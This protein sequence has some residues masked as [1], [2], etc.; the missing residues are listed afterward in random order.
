MQT[1]SILFKLYTDFLIQGTFIN[2]H[3]AKLFPQ[4]TSSYA[5]ALPKKLARNSATATDGRRIFK[6]HPKHEQ[7]P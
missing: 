7:T 1:V 4:K 2:I 5:T 6:G 3:R